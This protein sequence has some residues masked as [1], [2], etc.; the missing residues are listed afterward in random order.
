MPFGTIK[1]SQIKAIVRS[2]IKKS[3]RRRPRR[4]L[5]G[6]TSGRNSL[7]NNSAGCMPGMYNGKIVDIPYVHIKTYASAGAGSHAVQ[8]YSLNGIYDPDITGG[9]TQPLSRDELALFYN[10]YEVVGCKAI[11]TFRW[12]SQVSATGPCVCFAFPSSTNSAPTQLDTKL[13]RYPKNCKVLQATAGN[14]TQEI[15]IV[16][17]FSTK[18]FFSYKDV[19]DEHQ[20]KA[21]FGAN[22]FIQAYLIT[23]LQDMDGGDA[24]ATVTTMTRLEFKV[25]LLDPIPLLGS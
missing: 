1:K 21:A 14:A 12:S 8:T 2:T 5:A 9:G 25:R 7:M 4:R 20:L 22:P 11:T 16:N 19:S 17:Y 6:T 10:Q 3:K 13:E 18:K 15:K 23:G 24:S